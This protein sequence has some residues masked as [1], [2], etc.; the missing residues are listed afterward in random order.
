MVRKPPRFRH[1]L[2]T[3][4]ICAL[5]AVAVGFLALLLVLI[6]H[7]SSSSTPQPVECISVPY[8]VCIDA[9]HGG[10]DPGASGSDRTEKDDTLAAALALEQAMKER[11]ITVVMTRSDD[12]ALTLPERVAVA[13][14]ASANL[15]LSLHRNVAESGNGIEIWI[16]QQCSTTS[17]SLADKIHAN[18]VAAGVQNDRGI[19]AGTQS[20]N[21]DYYVL[22]HTTMP[23]VLIELGF[24]QDKEDNKLFDKHLTDYANAIANAVVDIC[25]ESN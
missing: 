24:L 1:S 4:F 13:E 8:T 6:H 14:E 17:Q 9:G 18:L 16:A 12:T 19:R 10:S 25:N 3:K 22:S 7:S 21:G 23:A 20:G 2:W 15:F 11:N 5:I